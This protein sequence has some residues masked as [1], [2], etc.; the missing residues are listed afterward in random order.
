MTRARK[1]RAADGAVPIL[2]AERSCFYA[3]NGGERGRDS[4]APLL[5]KPR[6]VAHSHRRGAGQRSVGRSPMPD[7]QA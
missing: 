7:E 1:G 6:Q 5:P 2:R 3:S 4:E